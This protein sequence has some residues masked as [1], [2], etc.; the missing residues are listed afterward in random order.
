[1]GLVGLPSVLLDGYRSVQLAMSSCIFLI[2]E[3]NI[4]HFCNGER[5]DGHVLVAEYS[6]RHA[7]SSLVRPMGRDVTAAARRETSLQKQRLGAVVKSLKV[8]VSWRET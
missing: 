4:S 5:D 1:M 6:R 2:L 7:R 3:R 8:V